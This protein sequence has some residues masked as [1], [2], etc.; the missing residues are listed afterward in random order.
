MRSENRE[1]MN[2]WIKLSAI[3]VVASLFG[4]LSSLLVHVVNVAND[5][6]VS[7]SYADFLS[8]T[9]TALGLMITVL[10][11][12]VAAVGVI[13]WSTLENKLKSH[14]VDYFTK[15]LEKDGDLRKEIEQLIL[16]VSYAG[17]EK[18]KEEEGM[19]EREEG[20]YSD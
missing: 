18:V 12:F 3:A 11:I 13:G 9:L 17:V 4:G 2:R 7:M 5:S 19:G 10:G 6:S 16:G 20:R 15:Q 8:I 1:Y 14:S